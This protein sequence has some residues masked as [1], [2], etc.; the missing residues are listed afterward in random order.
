MYAF[1][2]RLSGDDLYDLY[3]LNHKQCLKKHKLMSKK[4]FYQATLDK[5]WSGIKRCC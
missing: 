3:V 4:N 1:L 2:R 5:K